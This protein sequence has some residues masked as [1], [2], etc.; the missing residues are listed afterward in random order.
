MHSGVKWAL[1]LALRVCGSR[2]S[3]VAGTAARVIFSPNKPYKRLSN[4][5]KLLSAV[6]VR[7]TFEQVR[8]V[9]ASRLLAVGERFQTDNATP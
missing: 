5:L 4:I 3:N 8:I 7:A 9:G 6:A 1:L 2:W